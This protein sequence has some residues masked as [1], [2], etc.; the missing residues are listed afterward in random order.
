MTFLNN[1]GKSLASSW[2]DTAYTLRRLTTRSPGPPDNPERC[3]PPND[4]KILT[5]SC[6][7][8][9]ACKLEPFLPAPV[10]ASLL[11]D[12]STPWTQSPVTIVSCPNLSQNIT[13]A[14]H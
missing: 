6:N 1:R 11:M 13:T 14:K 12:A 8:F 10:N 4:A 5:R 2:T 9:T 7:I 3:S